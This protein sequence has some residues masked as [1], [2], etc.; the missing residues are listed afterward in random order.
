MTRLMRKQQMGSLK[1]DRKFN[2]LDSVLVSVLIYDVLML[3]GDQF[4]GVF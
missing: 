4:G 1:K 3:L 2:V